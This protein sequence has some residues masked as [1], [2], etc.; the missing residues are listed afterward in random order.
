[1]R[2][3][4]HH[5]DEVDKNFNA[6]LSIALKEY[7]QKQ[8]T[9]IEVL[10]N[11][12][13]HYEFNT[14]TIKFSGP[15]GDTTMHFTVVGTYLPATSNWCWGWFNDAMP[16]HVRE[17]SSRIKS[18]TELTQYHIFS[19]PHFDVEPYEIDEL[20]ALALHHLGGK[21]VFKIKDQEPWL[22]LVLHD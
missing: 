3:H 11:R 16:D 12:S 9:L 21:G 20:C 15:S 22:Y 18:L 19:A 2:I 4:S 17:N 7:E 1:M 13:W 14:S 8:K 6:L 5:N 10:S